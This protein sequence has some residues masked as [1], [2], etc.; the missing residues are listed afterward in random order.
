MQEIPGSAI[1]LPADLVLLA[2]GFTGLPFTPLLEELGVRLDERGN[3]AAEPR[4]F[5]TSEPGVFAAGDV[6]D[7][8]Y[9]MPQ[10]YPQVLFK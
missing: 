9:V 3:V 2:M 5:A 4:D 7:H 6:A 10:N 8:V 1:E